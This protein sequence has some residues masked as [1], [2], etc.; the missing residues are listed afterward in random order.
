[1]WHLTFINSRG[2]L[3]AYDCPIGLRFYSRNN[4]NSATEF[5][6][7][8]QLIKSAYGLS[9]I[10]DAVRQYSV[11]LPTIQALRC[12][13]QPQNLKRDNSVKRIFTVD[14]SWFLKVPIYSTVECDKKMSFMMRTG[15]HTSAIILRKIWSCTFK[16][17]SRKWLRYWGWNNSVWRI[18]RES[19]PE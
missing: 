7:W 9:N 6:K 1:M 12:L 14:L 5:R 15:K 8:P 2:R 19:R 17:H 10:G 11:N 4:M 3:K 18:L 16:Q 13:E